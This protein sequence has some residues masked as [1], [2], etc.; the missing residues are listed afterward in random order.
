MNV[1]LYAKW[2]LKPIYNNNDA[3]L[4][5]KHTHTRIKSNIFL[6]RHIALFV[7]VVVL[8]IFQ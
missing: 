1:N 3:N 2:Q 7:I 6:S 8:L 5:I 4:Y